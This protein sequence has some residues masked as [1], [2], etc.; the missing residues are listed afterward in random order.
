MKKMTGQGLFLEEKLTGQRLF[1]SC[2][3]R[4]VKSFFLEKKGG[5]QFLTS[6]VCS[7]QVMC[8]TELISL[9]E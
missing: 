3:K 2:Q 6:G 1:S 4:G 7:F 5:Q 8:I 9:F